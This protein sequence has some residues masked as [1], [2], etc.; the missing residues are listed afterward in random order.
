[1]ANTIGQS[2]KKFRK[3]RNLTQEE[4]AMLLNVSAQAVSKWENETGLPDI[5]QVIPLASVFG[6]STD[7]LFGLENTNADEE[8]LKIVARAN[9]MKKQGKLDSLLIAY[10]TMLEG[11]KKYPGNVILL[12]NCMHLGL[13]LSLPENGWMYASERV[14]DIRNETIRQANLIIAHAK[15]VTDIFAAQQTLVFLY[16]S[17]KRYQEAILEA[18]KFP[19]RPDFTLYS[20]MAR[21]NEYMGNH[22]QEIMCLCSEIDYSLQGLEDAVARLGKAYYNSGK[23]KDAIS[24]YETFFDIMKAIFKDSCPPP[25]H[26]FDSGDCYIL[27]SQA[28]LA[29]GEV[30]RAVDS[31]AEAVNYVLDLIERCEDDTMP[32]K[33]FMQ[34][35]LVQETETTSYLTKSMLKEGLMEKIKSEKIAAL[36]NNLRFQALYEKVLE[37]LA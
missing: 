34:S 10:D 30:D 20:N 22:L 37:L 3:E 2:I 23:Y 1:M 19:V 35:P 9:G 14:K 21:V 5:S 27:L 32:R 31:V 24:T 29:I 11:L 13:A 17:E 12:S 25:Y 28:Y 7:A 33:T 4:L 16:S 6:V 8:A 18:R 36:Q 26:D 15:N